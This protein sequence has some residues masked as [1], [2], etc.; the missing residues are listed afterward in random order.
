MVSV[1]PIGNA[2]G[3]NT[4]R[5]WDLTTYQEIRRFTPRRGQVF[6]AAFSPDGRYLA[7]AGRVRDIQEAVNNGEVQL[8]DVETGR[9][10]RSMTGHTRVVM[11]LAFSPDGRMLATGSGD[12]TVRLWEVA[13]G[14]ERH[15]FT[16]HSTYISSLAFAP[17]GRKLAAASDDA[18]VYIWDVFGLAQPPRP[19]T[20]TDLELAWTN[21]ESSDAKV[22]FQAICRLVAVRDVAVNLLLKQRL[23]PATRIES[24]SVQELIRQLA[25]PRFADRQKAVSELEKL[26]DRAAVELRTA[27]KKALTAEVRQALQRLLDGIEAG[28][29]ETLRAIRAVEV[30]EHIATP[31]AREHLKTLAAGQPGAEPTVA[32]TAALKRLGQ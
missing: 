13:T 25:S 21:L 27:A 2:A 30:L 3:E 22:A 7:T 5:V 19:V 23:Q 18:P 14:G 10:L 16:G 24:K 32:A 11:R 12:N 8:W 20:P 15:R 1:S 9:E 17:D 26:G 29:P 6:T 31:A 4:I 28:T